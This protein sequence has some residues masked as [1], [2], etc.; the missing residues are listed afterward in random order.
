M[1]CTQCEKGTIEEIIFKKNGTKAMLCDYCGTMWFQDDDI[2]T[3]KGHRMSAYHE[4]D[5]SFVYEKSPPEDSENE[6][7]I[8]PK[9]R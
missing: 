9:T 7:V 3:S 4:N 8:Y 5:F 6:T 2:G 1:K